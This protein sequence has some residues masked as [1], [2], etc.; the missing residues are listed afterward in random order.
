VVKLYVEGGG[1]GKDLQIE[2]RRGFREFLE[3][4]GLKGKMPAI[5]AC[6]GRRFAYED[7]CT[8]IANGEAAMLLVDSEAP[9]AVHQTGKPDEWR[10]WQHLKTRQGDGW[11]KP[12]GGQEADCHLMAQCME[13]WFLADRATLKAFFGQHFNENALPPAAIT[14]ETIAKTAVLDSLKKATR[15][16][17]PKGSYGKGDH[18][19]KL[20]A[21]LDPAKVA[22]TSP[23]ARRFID[24][25]KRK[26][27]A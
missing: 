16:C 25:L 8:A 14:V 12:Q 7:Y 22:A 20:L 4:A 11:D 27:G 9:I 3:K 5:T 1:D 2:C 13:S 15:H 21:Q 19:F 6:G 24:I 17:Q 26:M 10:P 23:W 18:S